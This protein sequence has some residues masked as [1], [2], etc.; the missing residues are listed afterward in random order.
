MKKQSKQQHG[1]NND[2]QRIKRYLAKYTINPALLAGCSHVVGSI[3]VKKMADLV[4]WKPEFFGVVPEIVIK[5][6]QIV[7]SRS[8]QLSSMTGKSATANSILF[9]SKAAFEIGT[10]NTYGICKHVEPVRDCRSLNRIQHMQPASF[11][12]KITCKTTLI[13]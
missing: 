8:S 2:N 5:G 4:L 6:G 13:L 11:S 1:I 7:W 12:P 10:V 9:I 3:E